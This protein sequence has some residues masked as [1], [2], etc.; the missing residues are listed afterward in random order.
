MSPIF[1]SFFH[2]GFE[3]STQRMRPRRRLDLVAST[4]HDVHAEADYAALR[5]LGINTVRDGLRWHLIE[6][7]PDQYDW[8]SAQNQLRAARN[9]HMQVVWD[10]CH[11]GWP[12]HLDI[13]HPAFVEHYARYA[14]AAASEITDVLGGGQVYCPVNEISFWAWAGGD[15]AFFNPWTERRGMEL[16]TQLVRATLAGMD[17]IRQVDQNAR[18]VMVDP[19]IHIVARSP[20]A[21]RAAAHARRAQFEAWD[22]IAGRKAPELGGCAD[23]LDI[24]GVNYYSNNQ[25]V[26]GGRTIRRGSARYRPFREI[27]LETWKRYRRPIFVAETG[28]EGDAR[29][30]WLR[31]VCDEVEA[32]MHLGVPVQGICLY[33]V[34]DYPGWEDNRHCPCGLMGIPDE[35]GRRPMYAPL[36]EELQQQTQRFDALRQ[37]LYSNSYAAD[38]VPATAEASRPAA[39]AGRLR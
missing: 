19:V 1:R 20:G 14:V 22:M 34:T 10:L 30:D 2:G 18:F 39:R 24:V 38:P 13:W 16:K 35:T 28:A 9:Q 5:G 33:P 31:Y 26:L 7:Q 25:W 21:E 36:L 32:A 8:S 23:M 4:F 3:C 17:A 27:L 37:T 11:Y 12:E 15:V 6:G 29:V